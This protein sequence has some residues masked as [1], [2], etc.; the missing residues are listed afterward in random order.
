MHQ[1]DGVYLTAKQGGTL[2]AEDVWS[3]EEHRSRMETPSGYRPEGCPRCDGF[4]HGHGCRWRKLRDQPDS[5]EEAIRRYLCPECGAVW[6]VLPAFIARHLHRTWGAIQSRLVAAGVLE[7]TGSAGA[8]SAVEGG[9]FDGG[10][11]GV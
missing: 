9:H 8:E 3:F 7:R 1:D 5:A 4:L 11:H 6:Q 2:I 10:A